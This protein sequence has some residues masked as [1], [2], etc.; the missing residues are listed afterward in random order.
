MAPAETSTNNNE[1]KHLKGF[2]FITKF[3]REHIK[4]GSYYLLYIYKRKI[5]Y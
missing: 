4:A 3:K 2:R 5:A 1:W